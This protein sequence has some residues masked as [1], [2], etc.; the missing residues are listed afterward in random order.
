[1]RVLIADDEVLARQALVNLLSQNREIEEFEVANDA[2]EALEMLAAKSYD[3]L[4]LDINMPEV[5]GIEL[6][7]RLK[8]LERPLP[9][10]V[11]VTAYHEY[12]LTAFE[13]DAVDYVLK[14]FSKARME[15]ALQA[16]FR[17]TA[18]E[19]AVKLLEVLPQLQAVSARPNPRLAIK[20][21]GRVLFINPKEVIAVRA[22]GNYVL[23][24]RAS[25][26][27]LLREAISVMAG[28]LSAYGFIR[29]HRSILVNSALVEEIR[30]W[31]TG[32]YRLRVKGGKEYMVT[33]SY[34]KNLKTLAQVWVGADTFL[35]K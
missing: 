12:A 9:S 27:Y 28:K 17:R 24:E 23:L 33:R 26:S 1:M 2:V 35:S 14:P 8:H 21:Q 22:E 4:L 5:S 3:V 6:L 10:V 16:A 7:D 30:P 32:E 18:G 11:F 31:P 34:K 13:K 15:K 29:I 19:R 25:G 20:T